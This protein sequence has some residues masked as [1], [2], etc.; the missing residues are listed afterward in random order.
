MI[1]STFQDSLSFRRQIIGKM[2]GVLGPALQAS[3]NTNPITSAFK[4]TKENVYVVL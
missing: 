4:I 2:P 3:E 1:Y